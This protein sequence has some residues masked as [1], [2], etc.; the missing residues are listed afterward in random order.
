[1]ILEMAYACLYERTIIMYPLLAAN[2]FGQPPGN[3]ETTPLGKCNYHASYL[4]PPAHKTPAKKNHNNLR[5]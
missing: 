4:Q 5:S 3:M 2:L 1:M